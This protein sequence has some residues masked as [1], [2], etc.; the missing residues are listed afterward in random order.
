VRG[1]RRV[2]ATYAN[3]PARA[4]LCASQLEGQTGL[5]ICPSGS[6]LTPVSS[7]LCK[8]ISVFADPKSHLELFASHPTEG[9]IMIVT[10]AGRD[11]VDAAAF[12]A[13]GDRRAGSH[14]SVSITEHADERRLLRT[15]KSCGPDAPTLASSLRKACRPYRARTSCISADDGGKQAR[16]PGRAR[17]KPLKPLRAGMPGDPG[18]P[19]VNTRVLSTLRT[20]GCGCSGHPAFPTP[21]RGAKDKCTAR[22]HRAAGRERAFAV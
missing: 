20:R 5:L 19:V 8:N 10:N 4:K 22:A 6:L 3:N 11:A 16:S 9:R 18:G 13:R 17:N 7:P 14:E 12:C 21:S 1:V 15:A 2:R